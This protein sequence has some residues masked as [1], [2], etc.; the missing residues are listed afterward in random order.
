MKTVCDW[1]GHQNFEAN[2]EG[3]KINMDAVLPFGKESAPTPKQ[4]L[5]AAVC[6]CTG[7]DVIGMLHK[8]KQIPN[9]F[10]IAAETEVAKEHPH[11]LTHIH[12]TFNIEGPCQPVSVMGAVN[13]SQHKYCAVS[14]MVYKS[15]KVIYTVFL[16]GDKIGSG[17]AD[18]EKPSTT[19]L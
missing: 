1:K 3:F 19:A 11:I 8:Y 15:T 5:L 12:L 9:K 17:Q 13:L 4:I 16:N 10:S 14:A 2:V 7:M 6:G 18:F